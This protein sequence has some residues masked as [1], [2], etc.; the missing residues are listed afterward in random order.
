MGKRQRKTSAA[1]G[2]NHTGDCS[3]HPEPDPLG[4]RRCTV[5]GCF[6]FDP[7]R[8]HTWCKEA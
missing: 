3:S 5:C 2:C 1:A 6:T 7:D 8:T 4:R